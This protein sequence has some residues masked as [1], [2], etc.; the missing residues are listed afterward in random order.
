M[1]EEVVV[2]RSLLS[3]M[4]PGAPRQK[5]GLTLLPFFAAAPAKDYLLASEAAA[6][7]T[8]EIG[9]VGGGDVPNVVIHNKGGLPVLLI[10]GEH[11]EGAKQ[12]RIINVSTLVEEHTRTIIPVSCVEQGRWGYTGDA[13]FTPSQDHAYARLRRMQAES[14]M[15]A[16][17]AGGER[18]PS[19]G[20]VWAEVSSK[21][22]EMGVMSGTGAMRDS[23]EGQRSALHAI[24]QAFPQPEPGQT[25]VLACIGGEPIV[26][27]AFDRQETLAKMWKRLVSGY[28]MDALTAPAMKVPSGV[29]EEFIAQARGGEFSFQA[30]VG[31]G[32]DVVMT[33][34]AVVGSALAWK[35]GVVHLALF[36]RSRSMGTTEEGRRIATPLS[37]RRMR[38][39]FHSNS[40]AAGAQL[41]DN[42]GRSAHSD[43]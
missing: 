31:I 41:H 13:G 6:R 12:N 22:Q 10:D 19:Q 20:E 9:E 2:V 17:R 7:G 4:A 18:R 32:T 24:E 11:L 34:P 3:Q 33:S 5:A 35:G 8:I 26:L 40:V 14:W 23:Y 25:G 27:D 16:A 30:P 37:R 21:H 1:D 36:G 42:G 15:V 29:A 38:R 39:H 43:H 28:A